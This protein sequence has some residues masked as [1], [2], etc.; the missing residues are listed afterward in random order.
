MNL[1]SKDLLDILTDE[2]NPRH[3]HARLYSIPRK[4]FPHGNVASSWQGKEYNLFL[5]YKIRGR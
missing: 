2:K 1:V 4:K 5:S 3:T